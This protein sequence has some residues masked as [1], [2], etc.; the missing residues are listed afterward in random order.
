[1]K[2]IKEY[3]LYDNGQFV[4]SLTSDECVAMSKY[5]LDGSPI[6][7]MDYCIV[8][9]VVDVLDPKKK[10]VIGKETLSAP[11]LTNIKVIETPHFQRDPEAVRIVTEL[12]R[13]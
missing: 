7:T 4:R 13:E 12:L 3:A 6:V 5:I 10:K 9:V 11:S 1:M 2:S 8:S